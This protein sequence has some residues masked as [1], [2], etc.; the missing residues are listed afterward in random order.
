MTII[1]LKLITSLFI[2]FHTSFEKTIFLK[3]MRGKE[4]EWALF[5]LWFSERI[6]ELT[7]Q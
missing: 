5:D 2:S 3:G 7:V 6:C 1:P 4:R